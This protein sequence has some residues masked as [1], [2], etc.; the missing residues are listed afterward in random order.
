[1]RV[2]LRVGQEDA[3]LEINRGGASGT[4]GVSV[5]LRAHS[6]RRTPRS[7]RE[8]TKNLAERQYNHALMGEYT[9]FRQYI[10][11]T[12][13]KYNIYINVY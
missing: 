4:W 9:L 2:M 10:N 11:T 5:C 6:P 13:N 12:E 8:T 1:M 7:A 3:G